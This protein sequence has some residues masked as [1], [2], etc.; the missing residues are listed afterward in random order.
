MMDDGSADGTVIVGGD[1]LAVIRFERRLPYAIDEVWAALTD[2]ERLA[3]WWGDVDLEPQAGGRFDVTWFNVGPDGE[4]FAMHAAI[5][6][7]EPPRL[8]ETR[9]DAH[10]ILRWELTPEDSGTRLTFTSTLDLPDE[11]RTRTLAGWHFHL[12]ALRQTLG[13]GTVDLVE[14]PEWEAMHERYVARDS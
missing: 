4:R 5:T 11:F 9:G 13:G 2:P 7:F 12:A 1:G 8:L 3:Q 10:G 14:L 6:A